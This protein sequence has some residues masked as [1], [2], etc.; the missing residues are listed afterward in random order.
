MK[1]NNLAHPWANAKGNQQRLKLKANTS[2]I[3]IHN[4]QNWELVNFK[5]D[6][7]TIPRLLPNLGSLKLTPGVNLVR[8]NG[9]NV[10]ANIAIS[11]LED[12]GFTI[13]D[14]NKYDYIRVY[15]CLNGSRYEDR[16]TNFEQLGG[17]LIRSFD[18]EEFNE[19]R[20]MLMREGA[21]DLPHEHFIKIMIQD[22]QKIIDKYAQSQHNPNHQVLYNNAIQKDKDLKAVKQ[23]LKKQ[24][25][26]YYE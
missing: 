17:S 12:R 7:K 9:K 18:H 19:F 1:L 20:C 22:N 25:R 8:Q 15:P 26:E 10:N 2:F 11:D 14:S 24:G 23:A 21:L 3:Y 13:I 6:K 4:P 16:F 5:K